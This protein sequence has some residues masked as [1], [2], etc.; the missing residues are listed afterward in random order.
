MPILIKGSL[1][2]RSLADLEQFRLVLLCVTP[3]CSMVV[4]VFS[5]VFVTAFVVAVC[6]AV[7]VCIS[8][9]F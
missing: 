5:V 9:C 8:T 3:H 1:K 4:C 7:L 2:I 6:Y